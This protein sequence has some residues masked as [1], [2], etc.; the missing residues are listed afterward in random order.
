M[1]SCLLVLAFL[2]LSATAYSQCTLSVTISSSSTSICSGNKVSLTAAPSGGTG[3]YSYTWSTG[4]TSQSINV[5]KEGTYTVIVSDKTP[6]CQPVS[7]S[8]NIITAATPDA[9]TTTGAQLVC[10]NTRATL[11]ATAPG[12]FYQW[13]DAPA[14]GNFLGSGDTYLT[15]PINSGI[16]F[17]VQTTV[18]GCT[19]LRTGVFV[20]ATGNPIVTGM[21]VCSGNSAVLKASG[22]TS[23]EWYASPTSGSVLGTGPTFA[24]PILTATTDFYVVAT[25]NG[26]VSARTPVTAKVTPA[27]RQPVAQNASICTG[28]TATLHAN[29]GPGIYSWFDVPSGGTPLIL[30]PDYT[31]PPLTQSKIYYVQNSINSCESARTAVTVTVNPIPQVPGDQFVTTCKSSSI[32]LSASVA[33][34][35]TYQWYN[36]PV[37]GQP[38]ATGVTYQTPVLNSSTTYYVLATNGGCSSGRSAVNVVITP[39]PAAPSVSGTIICNGSLTTL[40]A[41]GPGGTYEW[42]STA[43]GSIPLHTGPSFTTPVLTATTQYY[44]QTTLSGCISARKAVTVTVNVVIPPPIANNTSTCSGSSASLA[45]TGGSGTYEWYSTPTGGTPLS[46]GQ[47]YTT[48]VLTTTT[49]YYVQITTASGCVSARKAVT[50]TVNPVPVQPTVSGT[51]TICSGSTASL[52]ASAAAGTIQWYDAASGGNLL[53]SGTSYTTPA[54]TANT[55]YYVQNTTGQCT[56]ARTLVTITINSP[57]IPQFQYPA[58]SVCISAPTNP[59]PTLNN[60][61]GGTF[62]ASP[63]GVTIDPTTGEINL[64]TSTAGT[65]AITFTGNGACDVPSSIK[66]IIFTNAVSTFSYNPVYCQDEPNPLP[67]FGVGASGGTFSATP[68][69][70]AINTSTGEIDLKKSTP[71][72]L[73]TIKNDIAA[74]GGCS[75]SAS[76]TTVKI[77][78]SV[79]ISAGPNQTVAYG[80]T[81][82]INGSVTNATAK[83]S[84]GTGQF[85]DVTIK[86]P[87]YTPGAGETSAILTYTSN[88]PSGSC[89]PK[90]DKVTI[91]FKNTLA[92]PT[93]TGNTTCLGSNANLSAI[94]P[95]GTY[96]WYDLPTAGTLLFTGANFATPPLLANT[97]YYVEAVN[98]IGIASPRTT[99]LVTVNTI[100]NAP[101]VPTTPVC[102]GNNITLTP[103]DLTGNFEWYDAATGGNLLSKNSTYSTPSLTTN[104]SY[105]VRKTVNGCV[106]PMTQVDVSVSAVPGVTSSL[107]DA[108]CSGNVLNY[109]IKSNIPTATFLWSRA[110]VTGFSNSALSNQTSSTINE[111]LI[112]TG[113]AAVNVKY[114]ITPINNNCPGTSVNYVVMV[115]PIPVVIS[116][117]SP[118]AICNQTSPNYEIKFNT[119]ADFEWS[120]AAVPGIE[121][122]AVT[123]QTTGTIREFLFNNTNN[124]IAVSYLITSKTNTCAGAPF[125]V[126][127]TVN[128]SVHVTSSQTGIACSGEPQSYAITSNLVSTTYIWSRAAVPDISTPA[129]INQTSS[130][131]TETLTNTGTIATH[132]VYI[133]T[134]LANGCPGPKFF[135]VVIV[136]PQPAKPVA[137]SNSPICVGSTIQ[138]RTPDVANATFSW[139]GPNGYTSSMQ[140][141]DITNVTMANLGIYSL[142]ITVNGCPSPV[143]TVKVDVRDPPTAFAGQ[144]RTV[145]IADPD[146]LLSG[147]IGGGTNTGIWTTNGSGTFFPSIN[148]P[149]AQKY[150]PTAQDKAAGQVVLTLTSTSDDDCKIA[151]ASVT[152]KFGPQSVVM[153]GPDQI[154]CSQTSGVQ[155]DGKIIIAGGG[156][157]STSGTGTFSP[158]ATQVNVAYVPSKADVLA[159]SVNLIL[160]ATNA[161]PCDISKDTMNVSF[162]PPPTVNAGGTRYVLRNRTITLNPTVSD[163]NVQYLWTP[164]LDINDN[165]VKNPVITGI[166]DRTYTLQVTDIRGCISKDTAQIKVSPEIVVPNTFT[167]N[168]DGVNDLWNILGLIAYTEATVDIFT[169]YGQKVFHS[170]GYDKPWDGVFNGKQ[171]P[172]GVYY[173]VIDTKLYNQILS[174]SLTLI[175]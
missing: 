84:G 173:Y 161:G 126:T 65:Y 96:K 2:L 164:N 31:T 98:S 156:L 71:N 14:G 10:T 125:K 93:V 172:V 1:R 168:A 150:I 23:Y 79:I 114:V 62:S 162:I 73:Y 166:V 64:S 120:R 157:W 167:P 133:I 105:W 127:V 24:T 53:K 160:L 18:N 81:V 78:Q 95:G 9:P 91:T 20:N 28:S 140:N 118:P 6:G 44:V 124:P 22:G 26:C 19:S 85:S 70:L 92:K 151:I 29:P 51:T 15:P 48:P 171:L 80:T 55:T 143:A 16:I 110:Q 50:V 68:V 38:I 111:T 86:N 158:S 83:W 165:K 102:A 69:G 99:V 39:P 75:S 35:G 12:G 36:T 89:G 72:I 49:T 25:T 59:I 94:A 100:P 61:A 153:A 7:K 147:S 149:L 131:I 30:S 17:Y 113:S 123:G 3:P 141:P 56:S 145:C 142:Y 4:E 57:V 11:R 33:P 43:T 169:R 136:K 97:T 21:T 60:P 170:I 128:P 66:Y 87:V 121:N 106:S 116:S 63:A 32:L 117:N 46:S 154:V 76:T 129:V 152:I 159:G 77:D 40:T 174:G 130:T 37:G 119:T 134:P 67:S 104:Q 74:S 144:A 122:T 27:P 132:V 107:T 109:T 146:I 139:T 135:Y 108:V 42:Y 101:V 155:L 58:G 175:R 54:L 163:D 34:S 82:Q 47:A 148:Y 5:N 88:A 137:N 115:Y 112:N 13:F 90:S 41:T 8:I 103:T 45:A 138:L 52:T